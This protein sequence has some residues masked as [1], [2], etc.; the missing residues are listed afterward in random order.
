M[1]KGAF[2][3]IGNARAVKAT[4]LLWGDSHADA[5]LP[6]VDA[7]A[8]RLGIKGA[9]IGHGRCPPLLHVEL[10]EEPTTRCARLNDEALRIS[11]RP[12]ITTVILAA[13]WAYYD[14]GTGYGPD[15]HEARH[16]IDLSGMGAGEDRHTRFARMLAATVRALRIA[17]KKVVIVA[18]APEVALSVPET[19]ARLR[20][21]GGDADI[22]PLRADY[23]ARQRFVSAD[24]AGLA[25]QGV[26]IVRPADAL[27]DSLRC[28][29]ARNGRPLYVD[30]HH[31]SAFGAEQL[32]PLFSRA[33]APG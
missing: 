29:V 13:R 23:E 24:F 31:L 2:C 15:A 10:T 21:Y 5:I 26:T 16:L 32:A 6:A 7:A 30:Q 1:A 8:A 25:R 22:R 33:F 18:D 4:F 17:G 20:L 11:L 3:A 27:C 12:E 28:V 9:F 19:L 14:Q